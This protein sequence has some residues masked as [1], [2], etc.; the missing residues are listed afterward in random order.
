MEHLA[1][2]SVRLARVGVCVGVCVGVPQPVDHARNGLETKIA[3]ARMMP[4]IDRVHDA[5]CRVMMPVPTV[6]SDIDLGGEIDEEED[7]D[8]DDKAGKG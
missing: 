5:G 8:E 3:E 7:E 1:W 6:R 2:D 4:A